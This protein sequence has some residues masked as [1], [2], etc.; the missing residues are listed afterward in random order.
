M[1]SSTVPVVLANLLASLT[2]DSGLAGVSIIE[3]TPDDPPPA[4]FVAVGDVTSTDTWAVLGN[5]GR[6]EDYLIAC[7]IE[8]RAPAQSRSEVRARA[9]GIFARVESILRTTPLFGVANV[10]N[11]EIVNFAYSPTF[12]EFGFAAH[13]SFQIRVQARK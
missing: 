6:D 1:A 12:D 4:E 13:L 8:A 10:W 2:G 5:R 11:G 3:G 9:F 7:D